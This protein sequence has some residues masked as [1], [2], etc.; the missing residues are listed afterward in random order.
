MTGALD[1]AAA[2]VPYFGP[3]FATTASSG[4]SASVLDSAT[5][6]LPRCA[7]AAMVSTLSG[8][9][10]AAPGKLCFFKLDSLLRGNAGMELAQVL[11]QNTYERVI[12]APALPGQ[13]RITRHTR[14]YRRH[15]DEWVLTGEDIAK[16]LRDNGFSVALGRAGE[17]APPGICLFDAECDRDLDAIAQAGLSRSSPCLWVGS[18]GLAAA[19]ARTS[20]AATGEAADLAGPLLGLIGSNHPV[21]LEQLS[22]VASNTVMALSEGSPDI[23]RLMARDGAL[24]VTSHLDPGMDRVAARERIAERFAKMVE[25]LPPPALL[26]VSGGETLRELIIPL[27]GRGVEVFGEYEPGAPLSR[28]VDGVWDGVQVLSKSGAFGGPDFLVTL[29]NRLKTQK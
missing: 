28:L 19:L 24:F 5:R 17:A 21:M 27:G 16:T 12:I 4:M 14:Q 26:F 15:G 20:F 11:K 7:A 3:L 23:V 2:L 6:E 22:R 9:L 29:L 10:R 13:S 18:S 25:Y 8:H 1:G